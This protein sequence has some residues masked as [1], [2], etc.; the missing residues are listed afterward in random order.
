MVKDVI[1]RMTKC[2]CYYYKFRLGKLYFLTNLLT[3]VK[4]NLMEKKL[5]QSARVLISVFFLGLT[6]QCEI[7]PSL[8]EMSTVTTIPAACGECDYIVD[9]YET[10]G[11]ALNL[12]PGSVICLSST[13]TYNRLVF[14]NIVGTASS[15]IIIRN[16]GGV[17]KIYSTA[18]FGLKFEDSKNFKVLGTGSTA[19]YGIKVTTEKGFFVTMENFTTDFEIANVEVAGATPNGLGE[20]SGF[21]GIG[22]KTSPYKDCELF[23]D[24]TRKAWVMRNVSI[25]DN[26]IHD[27]GGEGL[28]IGHGFYSGRKESGCSVTTYSHSIQGLR[29]Y[30]NRIENVG[31]DGMQ[32]KNADMDVQVYDNLV[33]NYGTKDVGVHNEGL[34]IGEGTTGKFFRNTIDT[35]TGTGCQIQ[36]L[37]NLAIYNNLFL[38]SG[39]HGMYGTLGA[40]SIRL[41]NGYFNILNNTIYKSA[42]TGFVF[43]NNAGGTKRFNNNLVVSAQTL[44]QKGAT[45]EQK[46]NIFSNDITSMKFVSITGRDFHVRV[47]SPAI[48]KG[49]S[50]SSFGVTTDK[51]NKG[52]PSGTA[53]DIGA[54]EYRLLQ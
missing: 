29:V 18:G 52:R 41:S 54:Y 33:R 36:G 25:H 9:S 35:G 11:K 46:N 14:R 40:Y 1:K 34:F 31:Y 21:A 12:K 23:A 13:K 15:P 47:G 4:L 37:G 50:M 27:V 45:M 42:G 38:N 10:D 32:I 53:F 51:D 7:A 44:T 16:C 28:Y 19:P 24:P 8:E 2:N 49:I 48:D 17:A 6:S 30:G 43:F 3:E 5:L 20:T 26:Y 39:E 22:V